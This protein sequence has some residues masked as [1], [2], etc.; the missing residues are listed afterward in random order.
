MTAPKIENSKMTRDQLLKLVHEKY[1][2]EGWQ[3]LQ[4]YF[5]ILNAQFF[6]KELPKVL[7]LTGRHGS[8]TPGRYFGRAIY[9]S[10]SLSPFQ[11]VLALLHE[12]V[13]LCNT[14]HN[15]Y[16]ADHGIGWVDSLQ[17]IHS[18]LNINIPTKNF[19]EAEA[20]SWPFELLRNYNMYEYF[21]LGF[22]KTGELRP[23]SGWR[24]EKRIRPERDQ[25]IEVICR[26]NAAADLMA[27]EKD[28]G[29]EYIQKIR[30]IVCNTKF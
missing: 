19:T 20:M 25:Q 26:N 12:M 9:I 30:E 24:L 6:N 5:D 7:M 23:L 11:Q 3:E 21:K 1:S 27:L 13:H 15:I 28:F 18:K 14:L 29:V 10:T 16:D 8:G 2:G 17:H 4:H 22:E